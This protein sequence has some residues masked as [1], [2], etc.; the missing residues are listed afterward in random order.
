M[1]EAGTGPPVPASKPYLKRGS[2]WSARVA[3]AREGRRYVPKGGP[4]KD[5]SK[6]EEVPL[7]TG[8]QQLQQHCPLSL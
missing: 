7:P 3:A 2:G 6:E 1:D 5:Y 8:R 4:V